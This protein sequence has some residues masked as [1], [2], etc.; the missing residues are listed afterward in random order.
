MR[1]GGTSGVSPRM[2]SNGHVLFMLA[3]CAVMLAATGVLIAGAPAGQSPLQ[4]QLLAAPM[5]AC[6]VMHL[7]MHRLAGKPCDAHAGKDRNND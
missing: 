7:F 3:C 5:L 6:V 4:T 1:Q 2:S